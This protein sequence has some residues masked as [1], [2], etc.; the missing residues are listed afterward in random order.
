MAVRPRLSTRAGD[1]HRRAETDGIDGTVEQPRSRAPEDRG[2]TKEG[3]SVITGRG[4]QSSRR[5]P[6]R[7]PS[8][9]VCDLPPPRDHVHTSG[10]AGRGGKHERAEGV[11]PEKPQGCG[12]DEY[13][14]DRPGLG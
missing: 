5:N 3:R 11:P 9:T 12:Q 8:L 2:P 13:R 1:A 7:G 6:K 4:V 14:S 10:Q